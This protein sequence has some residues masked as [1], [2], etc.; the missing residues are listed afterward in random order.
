MMKTKN[1]RRRVDD[2]GDGDDATQVKPA[3]LHS[4]S[5]NKKD[6]G[7]AKK[8]SGPKLLS[9]AEEEDGSDVIS[10]PV[11]VKKEKPS[12][13]SFDT[14]DDSLKP[15]KKTAGFGASQASGP[16]LSTS[17]DKSA[18]LH[19]NFQPQAG[20]YT[21]EKLLELQKNTIRLGGAKP[22]VQENKPLEPVIVLKGQVKPAVT[23]TLEIQ[24]MVTDREV[25]G[26]SDGKLLASKARDASYRVKLDTDDAEN[27]L[28]LMGIGVG[29][30]GGGVTHIPDA[31]AIAAAKAKRERLRQAQA[32]PDYIPVGNSDTLDLRAKPRDAPTSEK[33]ED[34]SS[35]DEGE[36][37]TRIAMM[38]E[39]PSE[40]V[41]PGVFESMEDKIEDRTLLSRREDDEEEEERRWEEEQLRKGFGKRVDESG[42]WPGATPSVPR[43]E[44]S[45]TESYISGGLATAPLPSSAWGFSGQNMDS[46]TISQKAEAALSTLYE[47]LRRTR[48]THNWTK[49]ELHKTEDNLSSSLMNI[50]TLENSLTTTGDKYVYMQ[51]LRDY[52]AVLCDFLKSKA[53]L[54]EELEEH[55]Q[56]LHEERAT[57]MSERRLAD[58][59]D[60]MVEV[61]AAVN[62]A[63]SA[64]NKGAS[65]AIAATAAATAASN[66]LAARDGSNLATQLDE[67][68]RDV[69]LKKRMELKQRAQ[70]RERRRARASKQRAESAVLNQG[71]TFNGLQVEGEATS[72]ES[73]S[74]EQAFRSG[75]ADILETG[76][77]VF[78]DAAEEY[79]QLAIVK[80][81]LESWKRLYSS[82]YR[83]AYVSLSAP[84]L[85]APFVRLELLKW[86]PLYSDVDFDS[87]KWHA[88]LF[89]YGMPAN[90]IDVS[91]DDADVDLVPKLVEKVALPV[92]HHEIAHCWDILSS[93]STTNAVAAVK[94]VLNYV[95]PSSDAL[96]DLLA[97]VRSL[98]MKAV[99]DMEQLAKHLKM[100]ELLQALLQTPRARVQDLQSPRQSMSDPLQRRE[101]SHDQRSYDA[102][103]KGHVVDQP[104]LSIGPR[105]PS[106]HGWF[107]FLGHDHTFSKIAWLDWYMPDN[108]YGAMQAGSSN[109]MYGNIGVQ[110]RFQCAAGSYGMPGANM[111]MAGFSQPYAH[112]MN[113]T[114]SFETT[115]FLKTNALREN[116]FQPRAM[117]LQGLLYHFSR[118]SLQEVPS[119][120]HQVT[121]VVPQAAQVAAYRFGTSVRLLRNVAY[122]KDVLATPLLERLALEDLLCGKIL[123][124]LRNLLHSPYDAISRT[125]RV[126]G[127]LSGVWIGPNVA[128]RPKLQP[129]VDFLTS[130]GRAIEK[131]KGVSSDDV[132]GLV[133]RLIRML[134]ELN[135]YDRARSF[136]KT[137][138][139]KEAL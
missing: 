21:K 89:D 82:A 38:G 86:D 54:I 94:V 28:G 117:S 30:E 62:A 121:S 75:C 23:T 29:A 14:D 132:L 113:M 55:M 83:D 56:R 103:G 31:A 95:P 71:D 96:Q 137:F 127:A 22:S 19:S 44:I 63:V 101:T 109:P 51:K 45:H 100:Q 50:S 6:K 32:L 64:L 110:S 41:K 7:L 76:D 84:A 60:E 115:T 48:E 13:F 99:E 47:T 9:F 5:K 20:E 131:R 129:L 57:A 24:T 66:A 134:V 12:L 138:Q 93:R 3:S 65:A 40:K 26:A 116:N 122:W 43:L 130:T 133:R 123:P 16:K 105:Q 4:S 15:K 91:P 118:S 114:E 74:E 11:Y 52:I 37:Q 53:P 85:F 104:P 90:G 69:N 139:L 111:G 58:N 72:E 18:V 8:P 73:E 81:K 102:K 25:F 1:F 87:M 59:T 33:G 79:S 46:M 80:E 92:L 128:S 17:K 10:K 77:R 2:D 49:A 70:S 27:R 61:E 98:L 126:V 136:S 34:S 36:V 68:G 125:E 42:T 135:E 39:L 108:A 124:H 106:T 35:D 78:G 120:N 97:A 67:F 88:L 112:N 119:W 107:G